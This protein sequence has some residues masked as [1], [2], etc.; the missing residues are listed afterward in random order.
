MFF[1]WSLLYPARFPIWAIAIISIISHSLGTFE[2]RNFWQLV[3]CLVLGTLEVRLMG[4]QDILENV[5]GRSKATSVTLPG[6][7]PNE[8]RTTF[9][10]R[11]TKAKAGISK[12]LLKTDDLSSSVYFLLLCLSFIYILICMLCFVIRNTKLTW[13]CK[14][15]CS[16]S[17]QV[18]M[19][20]KI[21]IKK[22]ALLWP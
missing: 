22:P 17:C 12:N 14:I 3:V 5:P 6:W 9:M 13:G 4:C 21:E 19:D 8:V 10:G 2:H 20:L 11:T 1:I 15:S 18:V 7:S 16:F